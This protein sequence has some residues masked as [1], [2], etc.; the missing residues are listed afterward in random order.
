MNNEEPFKPE[1]FEKHCNQSVKVAELANEKFKCQHGEHVFSSDKPK[2]WDGAWTVE[3]L[4]CRKI[5][6]GA[7]YAE[8]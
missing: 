4:K 2:I 1:D 6:K 7:W 3:C 8:T 5:L